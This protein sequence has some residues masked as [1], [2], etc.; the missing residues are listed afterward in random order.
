M[1]I[2]ETIVIQIIFSYLWTVELVLLQIIEFS[3]DGNHTRIKEDWQIYLKNNTL[4]SKVAPI[5]ES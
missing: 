2:L 5:D 1:K 4:E 3:K